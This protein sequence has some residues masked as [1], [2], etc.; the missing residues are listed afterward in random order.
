MIVLDASVLANVIADDGVDGAA[1]RRS[2]GNEELAAPELIDVETVSVFRKRWLAEDLTKHRFD[3]AIDDLAALVIQRYPLLPLMRRAFE[4]RSNVTPH[5]AS[6]VAL[7]EMLK[8][9]LL[10]G[11]GRLAAAP[12][13][14]CEFRLVR[15]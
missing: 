14:H 2:I 8:C 1:A 4:L 3:L 6:Y 15:T 5:D 12:G 11:D 9:P 7:A 10:T 13:P